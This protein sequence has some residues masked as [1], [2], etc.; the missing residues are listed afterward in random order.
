MNRG[1]FD[2]VSD[3]HCFLHCFLNIII[4]T[5]VVIVLPHYVHTYILSR[6]SLRHK[7]LITLFI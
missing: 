6:S 5:R 4:D 1:Y 3:K 7:T 2:P